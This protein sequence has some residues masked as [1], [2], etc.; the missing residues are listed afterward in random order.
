MKNGWKSDRKMFLMTANDWNTM[1][2]AGNPRKSLLFE[3]IRPD[4]RWFFDFS[5]DQIPPECRFD[6]V[7][8]RRFYWLYSAFLLGKRLY[9]CFLIQYFETDYW[10]AF[11]C[12]YIQWHWFDK[13]SYAFEHSLDLNT[14]MSWPCNAP[15][16][17]SLWK[18]YYGTT[19][20]ERLLS[21]IFWPMLWRNACK[22][23]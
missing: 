12:A 20:M 11:T 10:P 9:F 6:V 7:R 17:R 19:T 1:A 16:H 2:F 3:E 14:S 5:R 8:Y 13:A 15:I 22:F 18:D 23:F 4:I 21:I